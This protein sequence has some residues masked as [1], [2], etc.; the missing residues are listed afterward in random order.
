M[1][2]TNCLSIRDALAAHLAS[3]VDVQFFSGMR[4][5]TLPIETLDKRWIGVIIEHR[6]LDFYIIHDGGKAVSELI[7]QGMKI[8]PS[9]EREF[10][11]LAN[12]YG[13]SYSE[14]SF[15]AGSKF[16]HVA[17]RAYAVGM[18]SA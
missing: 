16:A 17:D 18:C 6:N 10:G 5:A 1:S 11:L 15:Q 4:V 14:E 9:V 2:E 7:L 3:H 13:V 12:R 8:T